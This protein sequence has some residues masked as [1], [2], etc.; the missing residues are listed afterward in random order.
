MGKKTRKGVLAMH[1]SLRMHARHVSHPS[2]LEPGDPIWAG[3]AP[4]PPARGLA[5]LPCCRV[6]HARI[7]RVA[8]VT[9]FLSETRPLSASQSA[10]SLPGTFMCDRTCCSCTS[11]GLARCRRL[12]TPRRRATISLLRVHFGL[13]LPMVMVMVIFSLWLWL[14]FRPY[15]DPTN[16]PCW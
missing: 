1:A 9:P 4:Q 6:I 7:H 2:P 5:A 11:R 12:H 13:H 15:T 14:F 8:S 16:L 3:P 10:S